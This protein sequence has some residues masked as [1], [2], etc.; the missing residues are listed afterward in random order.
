[1]MTDAETPESPYLVPFMSNYQVSPKVAIAHGTN[2][3]P[4]KSANL[5]GLF[6]LI[7]LSLVSVVGSVGG[8]FI[9][10]A[11]TVIDTLQVR[12]NV[13]LVSLTMSHLM[14]T[15]LVVPAS[16]IAIMANLEEDPS[17]CHFQWLITQSCSLISVLSFMFISIENLKGITSLVTYDFCCTKAKIVAITLMIWCFGILFPVGQHVSDFGPS[18][19]KNES[20]LPIWMPYHAT[21]CVALLIVPT[22]ITLICFLRCFFI[23]KYLRQ[24]LESNPTED[25]WAYTLTDESLLKSNIWVYSLSFIMWMPLCIVIIVKVMK[26]SPV[27]Q[28][29]L[30]TCWYIAIANSSIFSFVY[31]A[32]NRDFAEAFFKLF[33]YC[34]CKSHVTWTRKGIPPRRAVEEQ[35]SGLRF[36][37]IPGFYA[38]RRDCSSSTSTRLTHG[39]NSYSSYVNPSGH[40][41]GGGM[42]CGGGP[43]TRSFARTGRDNYKTTGNL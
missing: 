23:I 31:A 18:I 5:D 11:I 25:P 13:F 10:S 27:A 42:M 36:H 3:G 37:I 32:T 19:C 7:G 29:L 4:G 30:N 21:V 17:I 24:Q 40:T 6:Q 34:C 9:I 20:N 1:M 12:G 2:L 28:E 26:E 33:Y 35:Q 8:I 14:I 43:F 41:S 38:P 15:I 16:C 39:G 22:L